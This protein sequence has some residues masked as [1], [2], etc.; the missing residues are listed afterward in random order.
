MFSGIL[1]FYP[2]N[3]SGTTQKIVPTTMRLQQRFEHNPHQPN[4]FELK[5]HSSSW[6]GP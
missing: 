3:T 2:N 6:K 1:A 5:A 4:L